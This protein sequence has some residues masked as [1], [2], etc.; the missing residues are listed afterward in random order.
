MLYHAASQAV[1]KMHVC[2][3]RNDV[4]MTVLIARSHIPVFTFDRGRQENDLCV[5]HCTALH[6]SDTLLDSTSC[7]IRVYEIRIELQG[8]IRVHRLLFFP[9]YSDLF[10]FSKAMHLEGYF[11]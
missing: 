10:T 4:C 7:I 9:I 6:C 11:G 5:M 3:H 1:M 8:G 2:L